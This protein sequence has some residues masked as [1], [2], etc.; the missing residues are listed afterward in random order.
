MAERIYL[1]ASEIDATRTEL[2]ITDWISSDGVDWGDA[3]VQ[4]SMAAQAVGSTVTDITVPNRSVSIPLS[5]RETGGTTF[6]TI[7]AAVQAK[8]GQWQAQGGSL[9]RVLNTGGT[10]FCDVVSASLR[11]AGDWQVAHNDVDVAAALTLEC[12]PDF[13][14]AEETLSDHTETTNPELIFTETTANGGDFPLGD[15]VRVVVD[16][17]SGND[18]RGLIWSFRGLHYSSASTAAAAYDAES[19]QPLDT[20]AKAAKVGASGGTVVTHGTLATNWTP[21]LGTN[22]G[23]TTYLS[24]QGTYR[25]YA[26]VF[27]TSS[28]A[29]QARLVWDVNDLVYPTENAP[30]RCYNGGTFHILDLG[31]VRLDPPPTGTYRWT[32]QIQ[33]KGDS[34]G[35]AFSVDRVWFVNTDESSGIATAPSVPTSIGT[36]YLVRDEFSRSGTLSGSNAVVGGAWA[37]GG[38]S[39]FLTNGTVAY[40]ASVS[41]TDFAIAAVGGTVTACA[42][43]ADVSLTNLGVSAAGGIVLRYVDTNNYAYVHVTRSG[44]GGIVGL[45]TKIGGV[46]SSWGQTAESP[47]WA[48]S[49]AT[50]QLR[51]TADAAGNVSVSAAINGSSAGEVIS[52][53]VP[54]LATGG[55]LA[56]GRVGLVDANTSGSA[57]IRTY[58]N[59][60]AWTPTA[61]AAVF[62]SHS[63]ELNTLGIS[64]QDSS[65]T[66]YGPATAV[67]GDLPRMPN[68]SSA[69]TVQC[70]VKASRGDFATLADPGIDDISARVYRRASYL[71]VG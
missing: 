33:A 47:Y 19:L 40:R 11:L 4:A 46:A 23:G 62:G 14:K 67:A 2:D 56:S 26:R 7:R 51:V 39:L 59:F 64:R 70:F 53:N 63:I 5:L 30:A 21:V 31:E 58:D 44:A 38:T 54:A 71:T 37:A 50:Y 49:G 68:R 22:I 35:E 10:V 13:Y 48:V 6:A 55:T 15:R 41:D 29:V 9:K 16:D 32:G 34:G 25:V 8:V 65:G 24:H 45:F 18:Q 52:A 28:T 20:A 27:T 43:Q 17:D 57:N 42:V 36:S 66:A 3:S 60:L 12:I 1:D 61:D 69:Q